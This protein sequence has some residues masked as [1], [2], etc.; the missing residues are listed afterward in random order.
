MNFFMPTRLFTGNDSVAEHGDELTKLGSSCLILTGKNA[1]RASGAL[2]DATRALEARGIAY[3]IWDGV[4]ANPPVAECAE[5]GRVASEAGLAFVLGIG[6]GSPLDAAKAVAVF[7]A[8]P[9]LDEDGFYAKA[10]ERQPLP[11]ALIGTTAGTG[12]EVTRVSVLT[13]SR[14]RK[15]SI[16]DERLYA[17]V[18]FGDSRYTKTCSRDVA[19][20]CGVDVL[21][22]AVEGYFS[23]KADDLARVCAIEAVKLVFGPLVTLVAEEKLKAQ[24]YEALYEAS[25]FAGLTI[26]TTSTCFPHNLGYYLTENYGVPHGF[27][28]AFFLPELF[29]LVSDYDQI[30]AEKFFEACGVRQLT[31]TRLVRDAV[32]KLG[33]HMSEEEVDAA[34]PRWEN[35]A[36]VDNTRAEIDTRLI[37]DMFLKMFA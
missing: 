34:L 26:N 2:D 10:W 30:Y 9:E 13:D 20:S 8:N 15:H 21:A 3:Q 29:E 7:A 35:N 31:L 14:G 12:S 37:R 27:A 11:V 32:P 22:H 1:A 28:C 33:I 17:R 6:G 36:S 18:A 25:I 19:L 5:A 23:R 4:T 24:Q 16:R